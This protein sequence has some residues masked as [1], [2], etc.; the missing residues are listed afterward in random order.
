MLDRVF[1]F[2]LAAYEVW[3]NAREMQAKTHL[4]FRNLSE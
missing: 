1:A 3:I 4:K 2:I